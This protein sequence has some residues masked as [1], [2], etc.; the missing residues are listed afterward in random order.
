LDEKCACLV[1]AKYSKAYI[2]HLKKTREPVGTNL[3]AHHNL[4]FYKTLMNQMREAIRNGNFFELYLKLKTDLRDHD[5]DHPPVK[6][7]KKIPMARRIRI[8]NFP[9]I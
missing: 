5:P 9:R 2:H 3:I 1:C 7:L 8:E 4:F 6:E